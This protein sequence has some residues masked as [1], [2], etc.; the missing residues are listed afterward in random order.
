MIYLKKI[1]TPIGVLRIACNDKELTMVTMDKFPKNHKEKYLHIEKKE[2]PILTETQIQLNEYFQKKR[3]IFDLPIG[4][5]GT[6]FQI[7]VWK[8]LLE[9]PYA[10]T[11]SYADQAKMINNEK[12][13][14]AVG[15]ANGKNPLLIIV[16][17]HRVISKN[18]TI[19]GFTG[20]IEIKK[21]LLKLEGGSDLY[22]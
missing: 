15:G 21:F 6:D 4:L 14:R 17:C 2:H 9:I 10:K 13:L 7:R 12:A 22:T 3:K 1:E 18:K 20:G 8:A 19:G 11:I 5:Y 16:P